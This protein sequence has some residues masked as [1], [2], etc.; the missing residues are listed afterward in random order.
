MLTIVLSSCLNIPWYT[1]TQVHILLLSHHTHIKTLPILVMSFHP[2]SSMQL[3][4]AT[5]TKQTHENDFSLLRSFI[6][7]PMDI[8]PWLI[9]ITR[10]ARGK[11]TLLPCLASSSAY[12][13]FLIKIELHYF[14][15]ADPGL[16][17]KKLYTVVTGIT[18]LSV[19][20]CQLGTRHTYYTHRILLNCAAFV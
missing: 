7:L 13:V 3:L 10:I 5:A 16:V 19:Y 14:W 6:K 8:W 1:L 11:W 9:T 15:V 12:K 17:I 20:N 18:W 2:F 4:R